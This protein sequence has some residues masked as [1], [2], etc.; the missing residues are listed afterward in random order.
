MENK[1]A[2]RLSRSA[3]AEYRARLDDLKNV[4]R[5]EIAQQIKEARAFGDI[6]ENAEY[7]AAMDNQA[8]IEY[9]IV[10]LEELLANVEEIDEGSID[11]S[12]VNVGGRVRIE[13][14]QTGE[15]AEYDIVSTSEIEPFARRVEIACSDSSYNREH[16]FLEGQ[17]VKVDLKAKLSNE[18]PVGKALIGHKEGDT[19]DVVAPGGTMRYRILDILRQPDTPQG[20]VVAEWILA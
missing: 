6:S 14:L 8:R 2:K 4:K 13:S 20:K 7:D 12:V 15:L 19:V 3:I 5:M 11:L 17:R 9:E 16:G 18:S 10:Q 1:E